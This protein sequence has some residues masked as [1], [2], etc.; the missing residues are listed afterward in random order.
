MADRHADLIATLRGAGHDLDLPDRDPA[1][2]ALARIRAAARTAAPRPADPGRARGRRAGRRLGVAPAAGAP[3][4]PAPPPARARWVALAAAAAVVLAV[5]LAAPGARQAVARL[6]GIGGV[7]VTVTG[8]PPGD[9][10]RALDLGYPLPVDEAVAA[11]GGAFDTPFPS[12]PGDPALA[13]AGRPDGAVSR[14]WPAGEGLPALEE[15]EVGLILTAFPT[16]GAVPS[17]DPSDPGDPDDPGDA[18]GPPVEK[19]AGP[20]TRITA[21]QVGP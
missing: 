1:A 8:D 14:V 6:L 2:A 13:F 17:G 4:G 16:A 18:G 9:L 11:A 21:V 3:P 5:V 20:G 15:S 10:G 19:Q 7:R 12:P